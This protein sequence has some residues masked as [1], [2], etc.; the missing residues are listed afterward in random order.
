[1]FAGA[2]LLGTACGGGAEGTDGTDEAVY[3]S[4]GTEG[5]E[6]VEDVYE[7]DTANDTV[8]AEDNFQ[9]MPYGAPPRRERI[10]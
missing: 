8:D 9:P 1:V 7:D 4:D 3:D 6:V 2:A 5:E 10:V